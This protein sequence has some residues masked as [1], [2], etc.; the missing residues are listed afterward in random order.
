MILYTYASLSKNKTVYNTKTHL[1]LRYIMY[2][3]LDMTCS[4]CIC[5]RGNT[6][7]N[8][9]L[10]QSKTMVI[11][12]TS[13]S[14]IRTRLGYNSS[15]LVHACRHYGK[16]FKQYESDRDRS[17]RSWRAYRDCRWLS[18]R[19]LWPEELETTEILGSYQPDA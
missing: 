16:N 9:T 4:P 18:W 12:S 1:L 2:Y 7:C 15:C 5:W 6:I 11:G 14:N 17:R 13:P 8:I 10:C 3:A 19:F